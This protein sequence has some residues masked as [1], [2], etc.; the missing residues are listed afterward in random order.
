MKFSMYIIDLDEA[1]I[2]GT[3]NVEV[4]E[5]FIESDHHIILHSEGAYFAGTRRE[6]EVEDI[7]I[8]DNPYDFDDYDVEEK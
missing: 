3:N 8:E 1:N 7:E 2:K 4:A 6:I 5:D